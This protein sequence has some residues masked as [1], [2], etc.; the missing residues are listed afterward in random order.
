MSKFEPHF[1]I[2]INVSIWWFRI[3]I[4]VKSNMYMQQTFPVKLKYCGIAGLFNDVLPHCVARI[5]AAVVLTTKCELVP[6]FHEETCQ[7][8]RHPSRG[9]MSKYAPSLF[10]IWQ[11]IQTWFRWR[12]YVLIS[13]DFFLL[14][15]TPNSHFAMW[16]EWKKLLLLVATCTYNKNITFRNYV[17]FYIQHSAFWH[18][19]GTAM[20]KLISMTK[21]ISVQVQA[22]T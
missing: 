16:N 3:I 15:Q 12:W 6:I 1:G 9:N 17:W 20:T 4:N 7:N 2:T 21:F 19:A 22:S 18:I 13:S 14:T 11:N 5:W 8:V 10:A